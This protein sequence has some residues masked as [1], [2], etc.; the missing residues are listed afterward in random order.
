[1]NSHD[2][3]KPQARASHASEYWAVDVGKDGVST[4]LHGLISGH[5]ACEV[6]Q[7]IIC[8]GV[9][10]VWYLSIQGEFEE[11]RESTQDARKLAR[12]KESGVGRGK[13]EVRGGARGGSGGFCPGQLC[14]VS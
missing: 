5:D 4:A 6:C 3:K 1:M 14:R 2:A 9:V 12:K 8:W 11:G 10:R 13:T 7:M